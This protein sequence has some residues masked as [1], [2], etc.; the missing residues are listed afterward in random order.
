MLNV[1]WH[2]HTSDRVAEVRRLC[3]ATRDADGETARA[4][5]ADGVRAQYALLVAEGEA[6]AVAV[7]AIVA[8]C[9]TLVNYVPDAD[10]AA[11]LNMLEW[12]SAE[13]LRIAPRPVEEVRRAAAAVG[14][15][16]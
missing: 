1:V 9:R 10:T 13:T 4:A 7:A 3:A 15:G 8:D 5:A 14:I 2:R 6:R 16:L 11:R 12:V